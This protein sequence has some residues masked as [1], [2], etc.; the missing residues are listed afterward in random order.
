MGG[1]YSAMTYL[2]ASN[3]QTGA[4][5]IASTTIGAINGAA[6]ALVGYAG[7]SIGNTGGAVATYMMNGIAAVGTM[8]ATAITDRPKRNNAP[9]TR[10]VKSNRQTNRN[11]VRNRSTRNFGTGRKA[12]SY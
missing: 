1:A 8:I 6:S 10:S 2:G 3:N 4:G 5:L 7:G 11:N 9:Q 12:A